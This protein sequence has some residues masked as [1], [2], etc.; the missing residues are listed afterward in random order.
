MLLSIGFLAFLNRH[1]GTAQIA[2]EEDIGPPARFARDGV[3]AAYVV[4]HN[5]HAACRVSLSLLM[6]VRIWL[7]TSEQDNNINY[8]KMLYQ[9][10][11]NNNKRCEVLF[12]SQKFHSDQGSCFSPGLFWWVC[13]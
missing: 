8:V 11:N 2:L 7:L 5:H 9:S 6:R 12:S 3:Q 1:H 4:T 10:T 13:Q